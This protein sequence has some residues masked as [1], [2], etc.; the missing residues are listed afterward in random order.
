MY[1]KTTCKKITCRYLFKMCVKNVTQD[2][3]PWRELIK[4]IVERRQ[5][6]QWHTLHGVW[7]CYGLNI[8][9]TDEVCT[10]ILLVTSLKLQ[11]RIIYQYGTSN[12]SY[13]LRWL[14]EEL[15][16][17]RHQT[18]ISQSSFCKC[19]LLQKLILLILIE[20]TIYRLKIHLTIGTNKQKRP[21]ISH[22]Q[23]S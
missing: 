2:L 21:Y 19:T 5:K 12:L 7:I 22:G 14:Y 4:N 9:L 1:R 18:S 13:K 3:Q 6:W 8:M 10:G 11:K 20:L 17:S 15:I 16:F 23:V